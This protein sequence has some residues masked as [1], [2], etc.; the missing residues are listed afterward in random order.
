ME[1]DPA[2]GPKRVESRQRTSFWLHKVEGK[3]D[4]QVETL[5]EMAERDFSRL[6]LSS[7]KELFSSTIE[8]RLAATSVSHSDTANSQKSIFEKG[9]R[10]R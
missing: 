4:G 5:I 7:T 2:G 6:D 1:D 3:R 8:K 10:T 9:K